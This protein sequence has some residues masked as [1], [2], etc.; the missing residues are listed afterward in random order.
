MDFNGGFFEKLFEEILNYLIKY[1]LKD[2]FAFFFFFSIR[3]FNIHASDNNKFKFDLTIGWR[4]LD[5]FAIIF[6]DVLRRV[7]DNRNQIRY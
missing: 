7:T 2:N 6:N 3:S 5:M 1:L 4:S